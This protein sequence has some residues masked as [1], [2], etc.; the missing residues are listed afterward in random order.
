MSLEIIVQMDVIQGHMINLIVNFVFRSFRLVLIAEIV[1]ADAIPAITIII[2]YIVVVF[3]HVI[4]VQLN[5]ILVQ[6]QPIVKDAS[7]DMCLVEMTVLHVILH[8]V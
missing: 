6:V 7:L 1:M 2:W 4:L 5:A 3:D 8:N